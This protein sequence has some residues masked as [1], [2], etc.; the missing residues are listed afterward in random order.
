[1]KINLKN[2]TVLVSGGTHGI[3]Q[4]CVENFLKSGSNVI[5]FSR[6]EK[7]IKFIEKKNSIYKKK[8]D[9]FKGDVTNKVFLKKLSQNIISK[10]KSLDIIVHNVGGGGRWGKPDVD[11]TDLNVWNEVYQKNIKGI[12]FLNKIFC[13]FM[14]KNNWGRVI[15]VASING[16][17][18]NFEDRPWFT[19]A[20]AAQISISKNYSKMKQFTNKGVTFNCVSPGPIDIKGTGWDKE[21]N[22]NKNKINSWIKEYI[23]SNRLGKPEEVADLI[24]FLSSDFASYI[25]GCNIKIDG[26]KSNGF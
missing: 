4:A 10:Y 15:T 18:V 26:G 21:K 6:D 24:L 20:K 16:S 11:K 17:E 1:M 12:I 5:T 25:N 14:R 3:G 23:P 22:K 2:K 13:K 8:L 19:A 7:K 9:V